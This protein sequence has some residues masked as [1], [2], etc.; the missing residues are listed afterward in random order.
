MK[1]IRWTLAVPLYIIGVFFLLPT[2][3][4]LFGNTF[5]TAGGKIFGCLFSF[6]LTSVAFWSANWLV[7]P[8]SNEEEKSDRANSK[9][10]KKEKTRS[11]NKKEDDRV[12]AISFRL[13][14]ENNGFI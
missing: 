3:A 14:K 11:R 7:K 4:F 10:D 12:Q 6:A 13:V 9:Q 1:F 8:R 5:E 2:F